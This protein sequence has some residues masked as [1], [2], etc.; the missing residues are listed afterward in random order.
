MEPA[1][2]ASFLH[3][4][5]GKRSERTSF[6]VTEK[7]VVLEI[8]A[9]RQFTFTCSPGSERALVYGFLLSEGWI[10]RKE[11]I[12]NW[13]E[14][15]TGYRVRLRRRLPGLPMRVTSGFS[16][17]T[18]RIISAAAE[19]H[20][21]SSLFRKTGGAHA[22][23]IGER[24]G[25]LNFFADVSRNSAMEKAIGDAFLHEMDLGE[26]FLF[27]S[28]RVPQRMIHKAARAG[29]PVVCAVSAPTAQAVAE[30]KRLDICLCGFVRGE[31][32]NVYSHPWRLEE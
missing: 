25:L 14:T 18:S 12:Q 8:E 11:D 16:L 1:Q 31:E 15:E 28:C 9:G 10:R 2:R 13:E 26:A 5:P 22:A 7:T 24:K 27:L 20:T 29:I 32:L 17:P 4:S 6:L 21:Q 3:I 30:A 23:A 19:F